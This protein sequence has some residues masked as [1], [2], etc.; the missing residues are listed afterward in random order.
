MLCYLLCITKATYLHNAQFEIFI[1]HQ[2]LKHLLG[3]PLMW[4]LTI[5]GYNAEIKYIKG[6]SYS[7]ADM[8][9]RLPGSNDE[10]EPK[11]ISVTDEGPIPDVSEGHMRKE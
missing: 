11:K 7:L 9:S 8:L 4:T 3:S 1:D 6:A 10:Q 5:K 2:P